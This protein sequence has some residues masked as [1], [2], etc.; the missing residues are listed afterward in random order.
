MGLFAVYQKR[1]Q[2]QEVGWLRWG[3]AL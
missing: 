3:T 1:T 2:T